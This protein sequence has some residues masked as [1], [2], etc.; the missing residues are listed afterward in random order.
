MR[1]I[2]FRGKTGTIKN[3]KWVYGYLYKV[4]SLFNEKY[5]Y[6]IRN[7][8]LQDFIVDENTIGQFTG[9][10]DK[11]NVPVYEGDIVMFDNEWTKP[12]E[13]GIVTWNNENASFQIKGHIPSSSMKHLS[14]MKVVGNTSD[15]KM[16][17][18]QT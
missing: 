11:N 9:L 16:R 15:V 18:G 1:K 17:K 6:Y 10:Y 5:Q 7:E 13:T 3:D 14:M 4:K 12:T 8:N 2:K